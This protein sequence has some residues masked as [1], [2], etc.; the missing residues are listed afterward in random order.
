MEGKP[1]NKRTFKKLLIGQGKPK[2]DFL[3]KPWPVTDKKKLV[4][5]S[6]PRNMKKS[7]KYAGTI[8][9]CLP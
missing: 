9:V 1:S 6:I 2:R 5:N 4:D 8:Y 7:T 3:H